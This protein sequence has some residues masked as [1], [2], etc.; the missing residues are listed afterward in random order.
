[1]MRLTNKDQIVYSLKTR[2]P[3]KITKDVLFDTASFGNIVGGYDHLYV[4]SDVV[5]NL[6]LD[7]VTK[8]GKI[9]FTHDNQTLA[10]IFV[11]VDFVDG[12][13]KILVQVP[14]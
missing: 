4:S 2:L 6:L 12:V 7:N 3:E 5:A 10:I 13:N 8:N 9:Y 11:K 14:V 1:M